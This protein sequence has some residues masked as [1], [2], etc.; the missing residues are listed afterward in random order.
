MKKIVL[1]LDRDFDYPED[2]ERIVK[3]L[4]DRGYKCSPGDAAILWD[5]YSDSMAAGW[6]MLPQDDEDVFG[7]ISLDV[8][9]N[10]AED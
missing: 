8:L 4:A 7:C 6:M 5:R 9:Q 2:V 1:K 10:H 3:V